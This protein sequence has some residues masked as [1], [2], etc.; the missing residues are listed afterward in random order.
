MIKIKDIKVL[1]NFELLL[2]F[3]N[4]ERKR[5]DLSPYLDKGV[6]QELKNK[7]YLKRV[8]NKGCFICW[9]NEQDLSADTLYAEGKK[10][11]SNFRR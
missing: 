6:F 2:T 1:D 10:E 8:S 3:G 9:P 5:F 7:D 4:G 11:S